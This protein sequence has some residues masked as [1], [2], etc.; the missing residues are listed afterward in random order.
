MAKG[1]IATDTKIAAGSLMKAFIRISLLLLFGLLGSYSYALDA[2]QFA[3]PTQLQ[4]YHSLTEE[5]RCLVCQNET[6][7]ES[8][9]PLALD[10]RQV[11]AQQIRDGRSDIEIKAY[12]SE[13][14]GEFIHYKPSKKGAASLLWLAPFLLLLVAGFVFFLILKRKLISSDMGDENDMGLDDV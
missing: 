6:I 14:Y 7:A 11:V 12:M 10:L 3:D 9:A 13:R 8:N 1:T 5:L 2:T 4:R